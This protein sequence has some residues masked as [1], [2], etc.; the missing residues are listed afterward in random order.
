[1]EKNKSKRFL[2]LDVFRGLTVCLMIIVN[3]QGSIGTPYSALE[4]AEWNGCTLTDLVFPSFLFA[5]GNSLAFGKA[6]FF[7]LSTKDV[8]YKI[9]KRSLIIFLI[10]YLLSWYPFIRWNEAGEIHLKPFAETRILS[11]LQRIAICYCIAAFSVYY[12]SKKLIIIECIIFLIG[13]WQILLYFGDSFAPFT[14]KGNAVRKLDF[15]ILGPSH[16]YKEK[17]I[18]FDPEGLLS[19]IPAIVNVLAGYLT[20]IFIN[21]NGKSYYTVSYLMIIGNLL[22]I[23][24]LIWNVS[25]P[26]N[27]KLWTSSF[28]IYSVAIDI[29]VLTI[30]FYFI[31]IKKLKSGMYFFTVFGKNPLFIYVFADLIGIFLIVHVNKNIILI[32]WLNL[33]IFQ[34]IAPGPFGCLLI[35]N[36]FHA[37]LLV[38]RILFG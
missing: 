26:F 17:G 35:F 13:Y 14:L 25:L 18:P 5:V 30:I 34:L 3:T 15:M 27:K 23:T 20:G 37:Y 22:L 29:I 6:K 31:E 24:S 9:I 16:M 2:T 11:V 12:F 32:D 1:M 28:A 21:K 7:L 8:W 19:T 36:F 33:N 10:G 4:H 38:S